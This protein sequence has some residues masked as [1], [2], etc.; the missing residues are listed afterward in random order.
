ML[1]GPASSF[2]GFL[3][4]TIGACRLVCVASRQRFLPFSAPSTPD[5]GLDAAGAQGGREDARTASVL[6]VTLRILP[7]SPHFCPRVP[8]LHAFALLPV[9]STGCSLGPPVAAGRSAPHLCPE[10]V[11]L[12]L[13][14]TLSPDWPARRLARP[15]RHRREGVTFRDW[16]HQEPEDGWRPAL[17]PTLSS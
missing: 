1:P 3:V 5:A 4:V 11:S 10:R 7:C 8:S 2:G 16:P 17:L 9:G 6:S 15:E 14:R 12:R 13:S